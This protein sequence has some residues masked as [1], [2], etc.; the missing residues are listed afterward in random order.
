MQ[1]VADSFAPTRP[2][3]GLTH[4]FSDGPAGFV[5]PSTSRRLVVSTLG[6]GQ[7]R[8]KLAKGLLLTEL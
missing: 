1:L 7:I 6:R 5:L 2:V 8:T 3:G 4:S